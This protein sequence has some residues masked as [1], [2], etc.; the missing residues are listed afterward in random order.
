MRFSLQLFIQ[1][2]SLETEEASA[3]LKN[4]APDVPAPASGDLPA[5]ASCW[6]CCPHF[7][8]FADAK[9]NYRK[10]APGVQPME[11][12]AQDILSWQPNKWVPDG[13][14]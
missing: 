2:E 1:L 11:V 8:H 7:D 3:S 14:C 13:I 5:G 9:S 12:M 4:F 10:K 6:K